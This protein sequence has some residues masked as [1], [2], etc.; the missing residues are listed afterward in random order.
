[1]K[2]I[3]VIA[4]LD[5]ISEETFIC[6]RRPWNNDAEALLVPFTDDLGIPAEVKAQGFEYF[7]E[8][9]IAR[10]IL[11]GFMQRGPTLEQVT[12]FVTYYAD[13]DAYPAWAH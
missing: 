12:D 1:M 11:E 2:L 13:N 7:L 4:G 9:Y 3:D 8:V 5:D 10:E 6:V